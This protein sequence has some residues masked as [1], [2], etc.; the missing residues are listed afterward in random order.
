MAVGMAGALLAAFL[1]AHMGVPRANETLGFA[2]PLLGA[3]AAVF[4]YHVLEIWWLRGRAA[5]PSAG[6]RKRRSTPPPPERPAR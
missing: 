6:V 4:L 5:P 1:G 3:F 2:L